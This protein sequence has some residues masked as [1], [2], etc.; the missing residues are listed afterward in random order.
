MRR[1]HWYITDCN[2]INIHASLLFKKKFGL[3]QKFGIWK[4]NN[5][6]LVCRARWDKSINV[7][8]QRF[9]IKMKSSYS[10]EDRGTD[11]RNR[12]W[13]VLWKIF[14][15]IYDTP[16]KAENL[17]AT[18]KTI[19]IPRYTRERHNK[20]FMVWI[21]KHLS[22]TQVTYQKFSLIISCIQQ[23]NKRKM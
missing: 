23:R 6:P 21:M 12:F 18:R 22:M 14:Q 7:L 19:Y 2:L 3:G 11:G 16:T 8:H 20:H 17:L 9:R 5:F 10:F 4:K 1:I 15:M 13:N